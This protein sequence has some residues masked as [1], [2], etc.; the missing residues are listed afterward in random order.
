LK[1]KLTSQN[2]PVN[3]WSEQRQKEQ[4]K[5]QTE[6]AKIRQEKAELEKELQFCQKQIETLQ[7]EMEDREQEITDWKRKLTKQEDQ[8]LNYQT[9]LSLLQ[10]Q[11]GKSSN[12][13]QTENNWWTGFK[14][15]YGA[16][17]WWLIPLAI[18][19]FIGL[20]IYKKVKIFSN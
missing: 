19:L 3:N 18:I 8:I 13:N 16:Y 7:Q 12:K 6:K 20:F 9:Q 1:K 2:T 15:D 5:F 17:A 11:G 10:Q 4:Q 14:A